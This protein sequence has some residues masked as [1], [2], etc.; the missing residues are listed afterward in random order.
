MRRPVLLFGAAIAAFASPLLAPDCAFACS[1]AVAGSPEKRVS[2]ALARSGA[3][4]AGRVIASGE[5]DKKGEFGMEL[6]AVTFQV[7]EVWKGEVEETIEVTT[8]ES[9]G[10]CGY[11]FEEGRE[12]LVYASR[13]MEVSLCSE[14][15]PLSDAR[16]D[17]EVL[18]EGKKPVRVLPDTAGS[19]AGTLGLLPW[20]L[21]GG[22]VAGVLG[23]IAWRGSRGA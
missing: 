9:E 4:F 1:C 20:A 7:S 8:P 16:A 18:G 11:T 5:T 19:R 2:D 6:T 23:L 15:K 14:T 21:L 3:V 13:G 10:S 22:V 12:Y 17:P